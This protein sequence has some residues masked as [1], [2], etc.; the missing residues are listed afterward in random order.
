MLMPLPTEFND[1]V[2]FGSTALIASMTSCTVVSPFRSTCVVMPSR[3]VI[4][5]IAGSS[6]PSASVA[7]TGTPVP[8]FKSFSSVDPP[9]RADTEAGGVVAAVLAD[10][11]RRPA[12][13]AGDGQSVARVVDPQVE[14]E[15]L[16]LQNVEQVLHG[17]RRRN[18]DRP[19]VAIRW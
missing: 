17:G 1:A 4:S 19:A 10:A 14:I 5:I 2:R 3:R 18:V 8:K 9:K 16:P 15:F 7:L 13:A 6:V 12:V 11:E